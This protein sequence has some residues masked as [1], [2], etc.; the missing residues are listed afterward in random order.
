MPGKKA[1][2]TGITAQ[3]GSYLSE[4]LLEKGYEVYG[5][6]RRAEQERFERIEHIKERLHLLRGDLTDSASIEEAVKSSD[7][8]EV[9]NL[10]AL[11]FVPASWD[12]PTL[13]GEV[14]GLG[15][16]RLLEAIRK[17]KPGARFYQAGTSEMFGQPET[18]PQDET[19]PFCPRSPYGAAKVY[20]HHLVVNYRERYN[21]FACSGIL[22]N[23]ESPRRGHEF[24]TRKITR[25]VARIKLGLQDKLSLGS[26]DARR[27]WG[28][29]GD[30]V[31]AMWLML[32]ADEPE[33]Y[34]VA[35]G[36]THSVEEFVDA[37]FKSVGLDWKKYVVIDQRFVRP[38]EAVQLVGNASKAREA[39]GWR[40]RVSFG[41]L[42]GMMVEED[43]KGVG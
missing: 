34:V 5:M 12:Q 33:D 11:S 14:T 42:V 31:E 28:F 43:I 38:P 26:L 1:L 40:P 25:A 27:D 24:V 9:Y 29:A 37:A 17:F 32:Q 35:T 22:F 41:E 4:F 20:S 30:Y 23:H 15:T 2:I 16:A 7:P 36:E 18:S 19:T 21:L 13:T 6:V 39:L 3:D 10:G 8:D